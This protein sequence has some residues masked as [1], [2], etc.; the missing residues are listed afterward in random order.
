MLHWL[1]RLRSVLG[2]ESS[3]T[4][5]G[6][7][8]ISALGAALGILAVYWLSRWYLD[9]TGSLLMVA[10]MGATAVLVFA[11]PHGQLS[12]PWSVAMGHLL[13]AAVGIS[14]QKLFPDVPWSP[15]LAV[16]L[17]VAAMHYGR[18][19]HPPGGATALTVVIG[20]PD[21]HALGYQF[22]ATPLAL[23]ILAILLVAAAFNSLFPW[24]RYPAYFA[25]RAS[26]H[27]APEQSLS[28]EQITHEDFAA[29]MA[30]VN[31]YLDITAEDLV[32]LFHA[33]QAHA[34]VSGEHPQ[35]IVPGASYSNGR[36][37]RY[38][39]IRQV[40][41]VPAA[42]TDDPEQEQLI[43][44]VLAGDG[45]YATGICSRAEFQRWARFEVVESQGRWLR[46]NRG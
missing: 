36:V 15:A 38:W 32:E 10:S 30:E 29:A 5:H 20:G 25:R 41:D 19:I 11:V 7:K 4:G 28:G 45:A 35:G 21:V 2:L 1:M 26:V 17:A 39:S 8:L 22:L 18:C 16:G 12:Q 42:V 40:I 31:S 44:K 37:G 6:E 43:Y 46:A 9:S 23:N 27:P 24:R 34:R 13:S 3:T 33:A 14:C